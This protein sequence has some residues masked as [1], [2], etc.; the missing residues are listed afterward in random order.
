MKE[1]NNKR[2]RK[3]DLLI[4]GFLCRFIFKEPD[5]LFNLLNKEFLS[6]KSSTVSPFLK[7][8]MIGKKEYNPNLSRYK[9]KDKKN[10]KE[11]TAY[12]LPPEKVF[13]LLIKR[14][15]FA[16]SVPVQYFLIKKKVLL[17]HALSIVN[18]KK[19]FLILGEKEIKIEEV[20]VRFPK[21]QVLSKDIAIIRKIDNAFYIY[22]SPF[23]FSNFDKDNSINPKRFLLKKIFFLKKILPKKNQQINFLEAL[24]ALFLNSSLIYYGRLVNRSITFRKRSNKRIKLIYNITSLSRKKHLWNK[25][26]IYI[27]R[28]LSEMLIQTKYSRI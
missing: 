1:L 3:I 16:I 17:I 15:K 8:I 9:I 27:S 12:Y 26:I 23:D 2:E 19:A 7:L 20:L 24:N 25:I 4:G 21:A 13:P 22:H 18:K 28:L 11:A 6:T 5:Y 10:I 14:I